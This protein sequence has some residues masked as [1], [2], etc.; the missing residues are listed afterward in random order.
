M[1]KNSEDSGAGEELKPP[2]KIPFSG[3][4]QTSVVNP[5]SGNGSVPNGLAPPS[6]LQSPT[7]PA[8]SP[9]PGVIP[10]SLG[11]PLNRGGIARKNR[12]INAWNPP[13]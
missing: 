12:Y 7:V 8:L 2:P 5:I 1:D 10:P 4:D 6:S 3:G 11:A 13:K 9:I